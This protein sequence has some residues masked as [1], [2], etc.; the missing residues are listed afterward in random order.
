MS[1]RTHLLALSAL[2]LAGATALA[3]APPPRPPAFAPPKVRLSAAHS[4]D[5]VTVFFLH[6]DDQ[7]KGQNVL[8]LDE[9]LQAK[10]VIVHETKNVSQLSIENVGDDPVFIQA[11][12]IVKG[13]QQDRVLSID[14][15][16]AA[17]SGKV[18]LSSFCVE[19]GRWSPRGGE[20]AT[21]FSRS[22][23]SVV[24]NDLKLATRKDM[25]QSEVWGKVAEVQGQ[26]GKQLKGSVQAPASRSSLQLTL[27]HKKVSEAV[28][29]AVKKLQA[30]L[31]ARDKDVIGY[32]VAINGKVT[33]ADVYANAAL[34]RKLWP[35]LAR[36]TAIE[37]VALKKQG[38]KIEAVKAEAVTAL[39]AE[40]ASGK[41]RQKAAG[42]E[43]RELQRETKANILFE[44][45]TKAGAVLRQSWLAK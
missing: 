23:Y 14:M 38:A 19:S 37:A 30:A 18:P 3:V 22:A 4:H 31:P 27:E 13:G 20:S 36:A 15:L 33:S 6:G 43:G 7:L 9:A 8:T 32:A 17:K 40:V 24:G 21:A 34:F 2:A 29:A 5:N 11:G 12:D 44:T 35:K 39:L 1:R 42:K 16:V 45:R 10:K 25:S 28:E 41:V 26:L